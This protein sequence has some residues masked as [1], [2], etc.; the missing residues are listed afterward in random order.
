[1]GFWYECRTCNR[2]RRYASG[3]PGPHRR[4]QPCVVPMS[5]RRL[6]SSLAA[7]LSLSRGQ[8]PLVSVRVGMNSKPQAARALFPVRH[9]LLSN[10]MSTAGVTLMGFS[11]DSVTSK[12]ERHTAS[13][14]VITKISVAFYQQELAS[15]LRPSPS[16]RRG[17]S[18]H[19]QSK[20]KTSDAHVLHST[21]SQNAL[22]SQLFRQFRVTEPPIYTYIH[23][24]NTFYF[25]RLVISSST[26]T[27]GILRVSSVSLVR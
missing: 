11:S 7:G 27:S 20:N 19:Q 21:L 24:Q 1:M 9:T 18:T 14:Q 4:F 3:V 10:G 16:T 12:W 15:C 2:G 6:A 5:V 8:R 17:G 25:L 23:I 13:Y 26:V 22:L